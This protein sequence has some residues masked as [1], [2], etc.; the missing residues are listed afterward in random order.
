MA[1][2]SATAVKET[3]ADFGIYCKE[4]PFS[5]N[6][7]A[8]DIVKVECVGDEGDDENIPAKMRIQSYTLTATFV[9]K[10]RIAQLR[11]QM[12]TF[13]NYLIQ[14][15]FKIYDAYTKIGRQHVRFIGVEDDVK[16]EKFKVA[17]GGGIYTHGLV[18]F[19]ISFKVNDPTTR[20]E[21]NEFTNAYSNDS[22]NAQE[23]STNVTPNI[24]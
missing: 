9:A 16:F 20:F 5:F 7:K 23:P 3:V 22:F 1:D 21:Y 10:G 13:L 19:R 11:T 24:I 17:E 12:I 15:E 18:E 2:N 14:G 4:F 6:W 8:R